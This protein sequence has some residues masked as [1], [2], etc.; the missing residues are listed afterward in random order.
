MNGCHQKTKDSN[1]FAFGHTLRVSY[2]CGRN[3]LRMYPHR[4]G[5]WGMKMTNLENLEAQVSSWPHVTV[6]P[7]RFG[8]REFRFGAAEIGHIHRGG[9]VDIPF[10]RPV[11]DALLAGGLAEEHHFVPNSGWVTFRIRRE[12]DVEH[13]LWLMKLSYLR[14]DLK[15]AD[16]PLSLLE[17]QSEQLRLTP[18]FKSLFLQLLPTKPSGALAGRRS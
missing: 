18:E 3:R 15:G 7:H 10:P 12:E 8:G 11:R 14:Y 9:I 5:K 17:E 1:S 16:Q 13:A 6:H 4:K 2:Q